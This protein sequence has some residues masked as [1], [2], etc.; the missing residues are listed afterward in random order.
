M[1][2]SNNSNNSNS[3]I[4]NRQTLIAFRN[5]R[6]MQVCTFRKANPESGETDT[7]LS[8][9]FTNEDGTLQ[10]AGLSS[11][12]EEFKGLNDTQAAQK[13]ASMR[14]E[15]QVVTLASGSHILCMQGAMQGAEVIDF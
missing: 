7:F 13:I 6:K 11:R 14:N 10:Y 3:T 2:N 1:E 8:C 4:V 15:L 12:L 9:V 5:H